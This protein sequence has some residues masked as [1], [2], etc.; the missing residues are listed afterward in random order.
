VDRDRIEVDHHIVG[1]EAKVYLML[2]KPRGVVTTASDEKGRDTIYSCLSAGLPWVAPVGRLD[3]ASEGLL[4]L[5][6]DSEWAAR[7]S[8]PE[9]HLD[10]TYHIQVGAMVDEPLV[11]AMTNGVRS[12]NGEVLRAKQARM[13][14]SGQKNTWLEIVLDEGKNRQIRRMLEVSDIEV[15][16][17]VRVAVGPLVLG[18]LAKGN[19]R[20]LSS[21]EKRSLD[22]A[23]ITLRTRPVINVLH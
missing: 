6:N 19:C 23:I 12:G 22:R 9:T 20:R 5:T 4:L 3:K 10:K 13:L 1:A 7:I 15:L 21:E 8:D 2:N 11:T 18:K 16:R 14:R 17:L